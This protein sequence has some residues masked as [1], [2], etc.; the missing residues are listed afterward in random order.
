[1]DLGIGY[2][3]V[4]ALA[5]GVINQ[6]QP[7]VLGGRLSW[8][9]AL[10]LLN[11]TIVPGPPGKILLGSLLAASMDPVGLA[12][13]RLRGV[14]L[15]PVGALVWAYLPNDICAGLAVIPSLVLRR[16]SRQVS[17][18]REMGRTSLAT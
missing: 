15:L 10:V 3:V 13:A 8:I 18:A 7:Q 2:E 12:I 16:L 14:E 17:S 5:I 1:M 4:L 11:P 9:C 6:W